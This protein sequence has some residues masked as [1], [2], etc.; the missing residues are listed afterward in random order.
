MTFTEHKTDKPIESLTNVREKKGDRE[1]QKFGSY[2]C[3][4]YNDS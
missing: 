4:K 2:I 3:I 1:V